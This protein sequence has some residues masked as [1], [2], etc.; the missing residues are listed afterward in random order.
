MLG[1]FTSLILLPYTLLFSFQPSWVLNEPLSADPYAHNYCSKK[2]CS[3]IQCIYLEKTAN[4]LGFACGC[5]CWHFLWMQ[6]CFLHP[7]HFD[8]KAVIALLTVT[9]CTSTTLFTSH[10]FNTWRGIII[11]PALKCYQH[12]I[13][14]TGLHAEVK[15]VPLPPLAEERY[16]FVRAL[17]FRQGKIL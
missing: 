6:H 11:T 8:V 1:A 4:S 14:C 17:S 7:K 16:V 15:F 5:I 9:G 10:L 3:N 12:N 2:M 13:Y